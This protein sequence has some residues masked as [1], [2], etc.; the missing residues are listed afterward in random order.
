LPFDKEISFG[1]GVC[2][3]IFEIDLEGEDVLK[4][5]VEEKEDPNAPESSRLPPSVIFYVKL[6][7]PTSTGVKISKKHICM[8]EIIPEEMELEE[9]IVDQEKMIEFF[10]E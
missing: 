3:T 10:V 7:E 1:S 4:K 2:D 9:D 6:Y 5:T 8:I